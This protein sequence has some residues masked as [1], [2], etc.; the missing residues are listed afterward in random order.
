[1]WVPGDCCAR[2]E[3]KATC[4]AFY[5]REKRFVDVVAKG[6][7]WNLLLYLNMHIFSI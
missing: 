4:W 7:L 5:V 3:L 6:I 2:F 1:M